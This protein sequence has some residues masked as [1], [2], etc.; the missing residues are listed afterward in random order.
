MSLS[1]NSAALPADSGRDAKVGSGEESGATT[2]PWWGARTGDVFDEPL[3]DY[4]GSPPEGEMWTQSQVD[5]IQVDSSET[6]EGG[7][8]ARFFV[9]CAVRYIGEILHSKVHVD[10][11]HGRQISVFPS[12]ALA[13]RL[14]KVPLK[15]FCAHRTRQGGP[16]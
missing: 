8:L 10:V 15:A 5:E 13:G 4:L 12:L 6:E 2:A 9:G 11:S 16:S 7:P 1:T 14:R 3:A